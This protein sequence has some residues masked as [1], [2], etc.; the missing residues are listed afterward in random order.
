M[1]KLR[2]LIQQLGPD[3]M[4]YVSIGSMITRTREKGNDDPSVKQ[5]YVVSNAK[6]IVRA[7]DYRDNTIHSEDTSNYTIIREN[8]VAYNPSRLN[9]GSI[10]R[11][12]NA[13]PGLVSPMYVVF[14][15][16]PHKM[17]YSYFDHMIKSPYVLGKIN[18]LK[19][20]GARFR[21][22]YSRWDKIVIP[23]PPMPVQKEI[24][25]ILDRFTELTE[26][27]EAELVARKKQYEYYRDALY[28]ADGANIVWTTLDQI[29]V[30]CD[31][32]R[33]PV[34][35]G[36]R[37]SGKYPY[38]GASGIVDYVEDYIFDGDFLLVSEDGANLL[39]RSTPIAFSISGKNWVNNHAHVLKFDTYE[40]RR[41]VEIYLN[42]IDLS[43]YISGG[44]QPK[45][46]QENLNKIPIP[47]PSPERVQYVVGV[48]DR[49]DALCNN[50]S[51]G[52]PAEIEARQKQY[53]Y[54]RDKLLTFKQLS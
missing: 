50:I 15:V 49:F 31:R 53:E 2:E 41:Y 33:K 8:M 16:D 13:E 29:S 27:V 19:E 38:Y 11:L 3:D 51:E 48:L 42:S 54:Y 14:S 20:E 28:A 12:K 5:V 39:A 9:I 35:K 7:E 26:M 47:V 6:G 18:S 34:T 17:M 45:L 10:A 21:F 30:N 44:A 22:E 37:V 1:S 43:K 24:V 40:L 23:V 25:Q 4:E 36:N 52:L 46:N 32:Q